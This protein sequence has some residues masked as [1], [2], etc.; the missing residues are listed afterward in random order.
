ML[1]PSFFL[2]KE[3]IRI[4]PLPVHRRLKD[5]SGRD[6]VCGP[7]EVEV[8]WRSFLR[9]GGLTGVLPEDVRQGC[10]IARR[11]QVYRKFEEGRRLLKV[12]RFACV[13]RLLSLLLIGRLFRRVSIYDE[14]VS[15]KARLGRAR[16]PRW[17]SSI[18]FTKVGRPRQQTTDSSSLEECAHPVDERCSR[19]HVNAQYGRRHFAVAGRGRLFERLLDTGHDRDDQSKEIVGDVKEPLMNLWRR[20]N[21]ESAGSIAK[22]VT[23]P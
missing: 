11:W 22:M 23:F 9:C 21:V 5:K 15:R 19:G 4:E 3:G 12:R 18:S 17:N 14:L 20:S 2:Q 7:T 6:A 16:A 10:L 13:S 1:S 8:R